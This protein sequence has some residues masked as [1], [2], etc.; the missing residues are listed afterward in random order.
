[1]AGAFYQT[2]LAWIHDQGFGDYAR[3]ATLGILQLLAQQGIE[4]G[5]VVE[6]GCGSGITAAA[7]VEAGFRMWGVDLSESMI[8][9]ARQRVPA[10]EFQVGS[11]YEVQIPPCQ[12]VIA[13]GECFNYLTD[14]S[15]PLAL[16]PIDRTLRIPLYERIYQALDPGGMLMFDIL[17]PGQ[18]PAGSTMQLFR[19]M[20]SWTILVETSQDPTAQILTRR[21]ITFHQQGD[22]YRRH[23]EI[24]RQHLLR[25]SEVAAQLRQIGFQVEVAA[26]YGEF[27]LP[28]ARVAIVALKPDLS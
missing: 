28:Q 18:T 15:L 6:L 27:Q 17:E 11:M 23:E 26:G 2:D 16:E 7:L 22:L 4:T 1:M 8:R 5:L 24:H 13:V 12:G 3:N 20:E 21:I 14:E 19:E 10:A 25:G 9:M